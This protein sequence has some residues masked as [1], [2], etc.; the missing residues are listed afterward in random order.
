MADLAPAPRRIHR[1]K[2][3]VP[4]PNTMHQ[5]NL[6]FMP[7]DKLPSESKFF[8]CALT[9]VDVA[10]HYKE[11]ELLIY[12]RGALKWPKLLHVGPG[13][14]FMG[15]VSKELENTK[16]ISGKGTLRPGHR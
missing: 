6:P 10:S 7:H 12:K 14:D 5:A 16:H 8:K 2:F 13:R 11:A 9:V 4:T 15:A 3:D 1:P